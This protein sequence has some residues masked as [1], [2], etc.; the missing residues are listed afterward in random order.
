[1]VCTVLEVVWKKRDHNHLGCTP[2]MERAFV[3]GT[4]RND[5]PI[6]KAFVVD[7]LGNDILIERDHEGVI[8]IEIFM[9]VTFVGWKHF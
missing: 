4:P 8:S 7:A 5:I 1:M 9:V 6:E 3:V 2:I